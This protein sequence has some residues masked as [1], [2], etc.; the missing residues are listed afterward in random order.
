MTIDTERD[1][2]HAAYVAAELR[3]QLAPGQ[4]PGIRYE[5]LRK[6]LPLEQ[7]IVDHDLKMKKLARLAGVR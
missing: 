6:L 2:R 4:A 1:Y 5:I 7:A 3:R